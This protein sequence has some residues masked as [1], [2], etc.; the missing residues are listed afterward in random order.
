MVY[1]CG[2]GRDY[3]HWASLG[4]TGWS[5]ADALPYFKRSETIPSSAANITARAARSMSRDR[6]PT[7][8]CGRS[9]LQAAREAQFRI[10]EDFNG[11][12][13]EGLGIS[14]HAKERR[15][16]ERGARPTFTRSWRRAAFCASRATRR[17]PRIPFGASARS[18]SNTAQGKELKQIRARPRSHRLVP[19]VS[20]PQ[21]LHAVGGRRYGRPSPNMASQPRII[22]PVSGQNLQDHPDFV[23]G[24]TSVSPH[25]AGLSFG[26]IAANL[27][28]DR[29][30][31]GASGADR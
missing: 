17:P 8:R 11:D 3:D 14:G 5:Y 16:L 1:I 30:V 23:F 25:F 26:G 13:Q 7:I 24:F 27:Q 22:C 28:G 31:S 10:A 19:A 20:E 12:E 21:L 6:E 29:A 2:H 18:A 9:I 15:A 4:N